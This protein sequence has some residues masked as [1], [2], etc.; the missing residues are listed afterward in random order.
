MK[1]RLVGPGWT[2]F[3]GYFGVVEFKEG[4]SVR[5]VSD[6]EI[7]RLA[8]LTRIESVETGE[9]PGIAAQM[10]KGRDEPMPVLQSERGEGDAAPEEP[11]KVPRYTREELEAIADKGG[12][13]A[14][15]E[16][17]DEFGVKGRSI[18]ELITELMALVPKSA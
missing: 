4:V 17:A 6:I 8:A 12:I 1:I 9:D 3:T 2:D 5:E 7:K 14:V 13:K 18:T 11:K 10:L 16:I 15:R